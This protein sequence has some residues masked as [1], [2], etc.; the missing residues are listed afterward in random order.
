MDQIGFDFTKKADEPKPEKKKE[1]AA[2][3]LK[4]SAEEYLD[5]ETTG[6]K[7]QALVFLYG[8][9][10][11]LCFVR[12]HD[13]T[14]A[15]ERPIMRKDAGRILRNNGYYYHSNHYDGDGRFAKVYR[16]KNESD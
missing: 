8:Q 15:D 13:S 11:H 4:Q 16:Y 5:A 12:F 9:N 2:E 14:E 7:R 1:E 10:P 3:G 6:D